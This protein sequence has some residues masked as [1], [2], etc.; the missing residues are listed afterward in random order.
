MM[1]MVVMIMAPND[2]LISKKKEVGNGAWRSKQSWHV[3]VT[4]KKTDDNGT[5]EIMGG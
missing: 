3:V 4:N 5:K 1:T 2:C